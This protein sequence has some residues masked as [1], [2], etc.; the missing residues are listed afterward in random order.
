MQLKQTN[1]QNKQSYFPHPKIKSERLPSSQY[2]K[3]FEAAWSGNLAEIESLTVKAPKG[4]R[5]LAVCVLNF[6]GHTPLTIA[7]MRN[8]PACVQRLIEI[9]EL[10]YVPFNETLKEEKEEIKINNLDLAKGKKCHF[11]FF[12]VFVF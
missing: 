4:V 9:A 3:L 2:E 11:G 1:K 6:Q 12:L 8:H 7:V 5:P 10:Q